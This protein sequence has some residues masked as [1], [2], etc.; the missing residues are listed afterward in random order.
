MDVI[1]ILILLVIIIPA[2]CYI[3]KAKA[4][5]RACIGCPNASKCTR[6]IC[7]EKKENTNEN[8]SMTN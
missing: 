3:I 2:V 4:R 5:G 7:A 1:L 8:A 6:C